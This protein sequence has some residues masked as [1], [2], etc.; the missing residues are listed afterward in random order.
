MNLKGMII[1]A[2][3]GVVA[4]W[5]ILTF[6]IS[7]PAPVETAAQ[8]EE[9]AIALQT[10]RTEA[11]ATVVAIA[12]VEADNASQQGLRSAVNA[13]WLVLPIVAL[14]AGGTL[15]A[16]RYVNRHRR[17]VEIV[18][19]NQQGLMPVSRRALLAG[20]HDRMAAASLAGYHTAQ[21]EAARRQIPSQHYSPTKSHRC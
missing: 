4:V 3:L 19:P 11:T 1:A 5:V 7:H 18:Y 8:I 2:L 13:A 17:E 9:Q 10:A 16:W 6:G 15:L 14:I 12:G 21:I 20:D